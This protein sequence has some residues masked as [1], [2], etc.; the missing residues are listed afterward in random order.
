MSHRA[1][2]VLNFDF[3]CKKTREKEIKNFVVKNHSECGENR[4]FEISFR[5]VPIS[6]SVVEL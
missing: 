1:K 6:Q 4:T 5:F 2:H 3:S